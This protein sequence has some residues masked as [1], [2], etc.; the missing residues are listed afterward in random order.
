MSKIARFTGTLLPHQE[1]ARRK[2]K[3]SGALLLYH[4]LGSG[5]TITS[6]A[7]AA[8]DE[9]VAVVPASLRGNFNK[10]IGRFTDDSDINV[11]SYNKF[12]KAWPKGKTLILDEP[13]KIGR[14]ESK[15]SQN[16]VDAARQYSRR[17]LLTGTP[18]TNRASELAPIIRVLNPDAKEIPLNRSEFEKR[19][20]KES[21]V[22]LSFFQRLQGIQPGIRI[23]PKNPEIIRKAIRGMVHYHEPSKEEFPERI[24]KVREIE[25]SDEQARYYKYVTSRANPM[26]AKKI[27]MNL[28]LSKK[29][30]GQ[31]NAFMTAARQ[32]SNSTKPYGG[33][34]GLSPKIKAVASDFKKELEK[35]PNHKGL[36]YS[37]YLGAGLEEISNAFDDNHI[38][39]VE[40]NGSM[41][42]KK[43]KEAVDKYN[44]GEVSAILVSGA[45]SE[46]LD[47]K[48][49][50]TVQIVE[51]HWNKSRI[52]QVVGRGIRYQSHSDLPEDERNV[53]VIKYQTVMPK[54]F[55]QK[56]FRKDPDTST[57][58]YLE[59]LSVEKQQILD[60]FL[61]IFKQEGMKK[62][63]AL[64]KIQTDAFNDEFE[65]RA[66]NLAGLRK[67]TMALQ[68]STPIY[69]SGFKKNK[70][71][72]SVSKKILGMNTLNI[73]GER[74]RIFS[75]KGGSQ[76]AV[77][78]LSK[79]IRF[80]NMTPKNQEAFGR[81]GLLHE[82]FE[83]KIKRNSLKL[84]GSHASPEVLLREHNLVRT[85]SPEISQAA[86]N[87][88]KLRGEG[89]GES[90]VLSNYIPGF[91]YGESSRLSRHAIRRLT[92][93]L[94]KSWSIGDNI[95]I[96]LKTS[97]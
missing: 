10:E 64:Q 39:Y 7:G 89:T 15:T 68:K 18:A 82:G 28:P 11:M 58:Q 1:E 42:D 6:I 57:D 62:A 50:R 41:N 91:K 56:L 33:K 92:P 26:L 59:N 3:E 52:E 69:R 34:E 24:D 78:T 5:K 55:M 44:A 43:K 94:K 49:T 20:Y 29:E 60:Q 48:G 88:K 38:P 79:K 47:L 73:P 36:V 35:N 86:S 2:L 14:T 74:A 87:F 80:T 53:K 93:M 22:R 31:I 8:D 75:G 71:L 96:G 19:F 23:S 95:T 12:I 90:R 85:A 46:G 32:V 77:K 45:G 16:V 70:G 66:V 67:A 72:V 63:A 21:P 84:Y 13:Q 76:R 30:L 54:T 17:I 27:K 83:S 40:F 9:T 37:N 65:K 97:W 25:A 61:D 4:G 81:F 51:P